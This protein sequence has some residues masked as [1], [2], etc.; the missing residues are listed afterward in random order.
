MRRLLPFLV[1]AAL[2]AG[3][4]SA[5]KTSSTGG[6]VP[7]GAS[8]RP[9]GNAGVRLDRQRHRLGSVAAARQAGAEVPW[10]R[11]GDHEVQA[12]ALAARRRLRAGREAGARPRARHRG[13]RGQRLGNRLVADGGGADQAGRPGEVQG[14]RDEAERDGSGSKAVYREKDGWYAL[15]DSAEHDQ[16]GARGQRPA[17][18]RPGLQG[19]RWSKLPGDALVKVTSTGSG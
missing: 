18:R 19:R 6:S 10:P 16:P 17:R 5:S 9:R 11:P 3:C 15:S 14:A 1:L 4:G 12:A 13:R 7:A 8:R 2:L